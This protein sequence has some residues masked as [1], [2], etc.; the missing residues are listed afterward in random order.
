L[1]SSVAAV[2]DR[3]RDEHA[4]P[5]ILSLEGEEGAGPGEDDKSGGMGLLVGVQRFCRKLR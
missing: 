5:S 1:S 4:L 3:G 2:A